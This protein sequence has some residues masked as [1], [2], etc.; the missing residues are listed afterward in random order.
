MPFLI[1]RNVITG[2]YFMWNKLTEEEFMT[3]V[4]ENNQDVRNGDIEIIGKYNGL[5]QKI[6]Y[7]CHRCNTIQNPI[8]ASLACG[9]GCKKCKVLQLPQTQGKSNQAFQD[10]LQ[11]KREN[12]QDIYSD[13]RYINNHTDMWFYCSKGHEW[14]TKPALISRGTGCPYCSNRK[15][16]IGYNDIA[17]T[18]PDI[19]QFLANP[20]DGYKYTRWSNKRTDFRCTLCGHVQNRKLLQLLI[21]G[22]NVNVVGMVYRILINL[23]EPYSINYL[24]KNIKQNTIPHGVNHM[25]MISIFNCTIRNISLNGMGAN[26]QIE[27]NLFIYR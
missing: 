23:A 16:L 22:L 7:L 17:T 13:D 11:R 3:R 10:E 26:I 2:G 21:E 5:E 6:E 19:F 9:H 14:L 27:K 25:Y 15:I 4:Y 20:E 8:A 24:L 1:F 18:S 12:G